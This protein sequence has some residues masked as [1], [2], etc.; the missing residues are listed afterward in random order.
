MI[1]MW[2]NPMI[3]EVSSGREIMKPGVEG[4]KSKLWEWREKENKY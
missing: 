1:L 3:P 4:R 2:K